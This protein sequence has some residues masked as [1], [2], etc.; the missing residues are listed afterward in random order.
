M[1]RLLFVCFALSS[2][3]PAYADIDAAKAQAIAGQHMCLSCHAVDHKVVGPAYRD[4]AHKYKGDTDA[5]AALMKKVKG[6]GAGAWGPVAMPP[7]PGISDADLQVVL[8]WVLAG[9]PTQ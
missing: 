2:A 9:A 6:G 1:K 5:M 8:A 4:V 7:N 3:V